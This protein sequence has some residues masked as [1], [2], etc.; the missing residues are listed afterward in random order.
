[1]DGAVL[2]KAADSGRRAVVSTDGGRSAILS[3]AA[4]DCPTPGNNRAGS[5]FSL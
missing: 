5:A 4:R 1:M 3:D 2:L